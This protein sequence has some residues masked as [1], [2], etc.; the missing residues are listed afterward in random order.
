MRGTEESLA[1]TFP[2]GLY[3]PCRPV[4]MVAVRGPRA[5]SVH[6]DGG[7]A[8]TWL[9]LITPGEEAGPGG[10]SC[11]LVGLGCKAGGSDVQRRE[12]ALSFTSLCLE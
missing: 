7:T 8:S 4:D 2:P 12:S 6:P 3:P 11:W 1:L 5:S 10:C 9:F